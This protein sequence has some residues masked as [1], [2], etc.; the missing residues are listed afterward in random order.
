MEKLLSRKEVALRWRKSEKS[1][2]RT[3][4][5]FTRIGRTAFYKVST[6]EKYEAAHA[7]RPASWKGAA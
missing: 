5:L 2:K 1:V 7:S 4:M 6:I 3:G